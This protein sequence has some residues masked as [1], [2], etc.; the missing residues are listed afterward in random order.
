MNNDTPD[1][2]GPMYSA[3]LDKGWTLRDLADKLTASG[4]P[5]SDGNLSR[6]ER[7]EVSPGPRLR[8]AIAD[9]L[10]IKTTDL[11]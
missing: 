3:R 1:S 8:K 7:G 6:I 11:P 5:A 2:R 10:G 9:A 4:V